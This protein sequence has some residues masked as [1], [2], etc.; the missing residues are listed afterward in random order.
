MMNSMGVVLSSC[1]VTG[2]SSRSAFKGRGPSAKERKCGAGGG[3]N[4]QEGRVNVRVIAYGQPPLLVHGGGF[5]G[6]R[7]PGSPPGRFAGPAE[8]L[9]RR[10]PRCRHGASPHT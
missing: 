1:A 9:A 6:K 8:T 5:W 3:V 10:G 7:V 2:S 4:R